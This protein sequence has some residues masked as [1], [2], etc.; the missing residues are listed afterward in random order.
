MK[1]RFFM[2]G[3]D[4]ALRCPDTAARR[5]YHH[6]DRIALLFCFFIL[7]SA[8]CNRALGQAAIDW[9]GM[10]G[11]GGIGPAVGNYQLIG[12]IGQ[13]VA[14]NPA[15]D[16]NLG[17][18]DQAS[19]ASGFLSVAVVDTFST[20]ALISSV[21]PSGFKD[22][23]MFTASLPGNAKGNVVFKTNNAVLNTVPVLGAVTSVSTALL[24]RQENTVAAEYSGD[25]YHA[26]STASLI[27]TVT[28]HPPAAGTHFLGTPLNTALNLSAVTLAGLDFDRDGD[29]LTITA[30][31]G[32]TVA[33][34]TVLLSEGAITYTP[35]INYVGADLFTY[36]IQDG[37]GGTN[38]GTARITVRLGNATSVFKSIAPEGA[39]VN[40]RGY[41]IPGHSYDIQVSSNMQDWTTLTTVAAAPNG[42]ILYTDTSPQGSGQRFYRFAVH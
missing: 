18:N 39:N 10:V 5:P 4:S 24:P 28:N 35:A 27:Q 12:T 16:T 8:F 13:P 11:G 33:G 41:G 22:S 38:L 32:N 20:L 36:A 6:P 15:P 23:V 25:F 40:L 3:R 19:L 30:V 29:P 37:F 1:K 34:G 21:N 14:S 17:P 42:L 2:R 9:H 26:A 31:S 7:H